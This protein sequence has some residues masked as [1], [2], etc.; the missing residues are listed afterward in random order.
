M[1]YFDRTYLNIRDALALALAPGHFPVFTRSKNP[2]RLQG[3]RTGLTLQALAPFGVVDVPLWRP[4]DVPHGPDGYALK[5]PTVRDIAVAVRALRRCLQELKR[6]WEAFCAR[7]CFYVVSGRVQ[8]KVIVHVHEMAAGL[9][10]SCA[11]YPCKWIMN[12]GQAYPALAR[13][14]KA[15]GNDLG[16]ETFERLLEIAASASAFDFYANESPEHRKARV[17]VLKTTI[18]K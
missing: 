9:D 5:A 17:D 2:N 13:A 4:E 11:F 3:T 7:R 12:P 10:G 8:V 14:V 18:S 15:A 16:S 6:E 1:A